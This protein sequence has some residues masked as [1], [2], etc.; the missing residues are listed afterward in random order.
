MA[1]E[2][3]RFLCSDR[4]SLMYSMRAVGDIA[5]SLT[6][7]MSVMPRMSRIVPT[8]PAPLREPDVEGATVLTT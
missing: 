5:S 3:A 1:D 2:W 6:L 7:H 4:I 8:N